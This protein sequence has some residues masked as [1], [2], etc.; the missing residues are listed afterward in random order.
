MGCLPYDFHFP[1]VVIPPKKQKSGLRHFFCLYQLLLSL[2]ACKAPATLTNDTQHRARDSNYH[3]SIHRIETH[4]TIILIRPYPKTS[5][6]SPKKGGEK[7]PPF[8][9]GAGRV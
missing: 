3:A 4:D 8:K 1:I 7:F 9:G 2:V 5:S 6:V